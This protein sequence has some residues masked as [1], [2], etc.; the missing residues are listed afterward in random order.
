MGVCF[1]GGGQCTES[2]RAGPLEQGAVQ[3]VIT[4]DWKELS[5]FF[6]HVKVDHDTSHARINIKRNDSPLS[7]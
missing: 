3:G 4:R 5:G 1:R 6:F 2:I 7:Y